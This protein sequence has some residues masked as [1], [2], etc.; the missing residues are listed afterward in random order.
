MYLTVGPTDLNI[1]INCAPSTTVKNLVIRALALGY[2]SVAL[3][4]E[5]S[6]EELLSSRKKRQQNKKSRDK[7]CV[8]PSPIVNNDAVPAPVS[9]NLSEFDYPDLAIKGRKP[10]I[11]NRL[12]LTVTTNDFLIDVKNSDNIKKYNIIAVIPSSSQTV[13]SLLSSSF[14]FDIVTFHVDNVRNG[15]RWSR[16]LYYECVENN[17]YF[18]I[19]YAPAIRDS[20]HRRTIIS[21][22]HNYHA[23]GRSK[24]IFFSSSAKS[25][26]ELRSPADVANL[27]FIFGLTEN[28]GKSA[29]NATCH[30]ISKAAAGRKMGP[31]RVRIEKLDK[32]DPN[33]V[34]SQSDSDQQSGSNDG[35]S[36]EDGDISASIG[37][38]YSIDH[39]EVN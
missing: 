11:L 23:V 30:A 38:D 32:A 12:T 1:P 8:D 4:T 33:L 15:V 18:E 3:N 14:R 6:Q 19:M 34:P 24:H 5:I 21:Q 13:G 27:A 16:K 35:D 39:M 10:I 9:L 25:P 7:K 31:F 28:A 36:S 22:A 2:Q 17:I 29:V 37:A 20:T 26:I